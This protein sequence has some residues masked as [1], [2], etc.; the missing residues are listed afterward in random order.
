MKTQITHLTL[1]NWRNFRRVDVAIGARAFIVG[2]NAS[3]KTNLL[4]AIRF[5]GEIA[6]KGG[7]LARSVNTSRGGIAH[8]RSLHARQAT[9]LRIEISIQV[10][11]DAWVYELCL[12]GTKTKPVRVLRERVGKN[13]KD[14]FLRPTSQD[15]ADP[16][17][18]EQTHLEQLSQNAHFRALADALAGITLIHVV[19]QVVKSPLRSEENALRDASGSDFIDQLARLPEKRRRG[20]LGRIERLLRVAVPHFSQLRSTRDNEGRPHLEA[21]YE[22]W[23]DKG[24]WQNET[25]FSDGTIRLIGFLWAISSG[26]APLLLEE[27]ELSLHREVVKQIPRVL[28]RA[29]E[30]SGRQVIVSTHAEE[31]VDDT[32][33]DPAEV[34]VLAPTKEETKV[35]TADQDLRLVNAARAGIPLGALLIGTTRPAGIEQLAMTPPVDSARR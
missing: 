16:R 10:D 30:H 2:P 11:S 3:G 34:I 25:E 18:L 1:E 20:V 26:S 33:I 27:P 7:S 14:L 35:T 13:G 24:S 22:H 12:G 8:L 17:L 31:M 4:D 29:S 5:L 23:R 6:R 15:E 9:D 32:G 28:A 21:N 19:P